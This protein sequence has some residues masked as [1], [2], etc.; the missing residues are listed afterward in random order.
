MNKYLLLSLILVF[1][2]LFCCSCSEKQSDAFIKINKSKID[3]GNNAESFTVPISTNIEG[4]QVKPKDNWCHAAIK[5]NQLQINVDENPGRFVRETKIFLSGQNQE[6]ELTIRQL[7][8]DPVILV[9][10]Q[11]VEM[12]AVGGSI[13]LSV[14]TNIDVKVVLP[15]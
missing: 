10:Q 7:G 5:N 1:A 4:L 14:T 11:Y 8:Y 2:N 13:T 15:S 9:D 3:F 6:V 12:S